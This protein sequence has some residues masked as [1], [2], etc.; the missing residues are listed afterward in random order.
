MKVRAWRG[1]PIYGDCLQLNVTWSGISCTQRSANKSTLFPF[2]KLSGR[3]S[4]KLEGYR[5][6][7]KFTGNLQQSGIFC[8]LYFGV[9]VIKNLQFLFSLPYGS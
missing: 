4:D 6:N 7:L 3:L 9:G 1:I 5:T 8:H 2:F